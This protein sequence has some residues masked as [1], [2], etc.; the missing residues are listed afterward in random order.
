VSCDADVP[1]ELIGDDERLG[2]ILDI[3][4]GNA[5]STT[6][7]G[8]VIVG[9]RISRDTGPAAGAPADPSADA[10]AT[11][12]G[13]ADDGVYA[14]ITL[15]VS[16][17]G[18]GLKDSE[19]AE[20]HAGAASAQSMGALA[21]DA[22]R[23]LEAKAT[24]HGSDARARVLET[25][26]AH[27]LAICSQLVKLFGS[28]VHVWTASTEGTILSF[29]VR[30]KVNTSPPPPSRAALVLAA[31]ALASGPLKRVVI[32]DPCDDLRAVLA[33]GLAAAIP[34]I[35]I[36]PVTT[37]A[38]ARTAALAKADSGLGTVVFLNYPNTEAYSQFVSEA[39]PAVA[40]PLDAAAAK[41]ASASAE[42]VALVAMLPLN[43]TG[44]TA[45][46]AASFD[47]RTPYRLSK[48]VAVHQLLDLLARVCED[49]M[50]PTLPSPNTMRRKTTRGIAQ[51][52]SS[53]RLGGSGLVSKCGFI[54][55]YIYVLEK[56][57]FFFFFFFFFCFQCC[58]YSFIH[59]GIGITCNVYI[60]IFR[61][62]IKRGRN[63]AI[64]IGWRTSQQS[65][66]WRNGSRAAAGADRR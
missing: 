20:L 62:R 26:A 6:S 58:A 52:S 59:H 54:R 15:S 14:S 39:D 43:G 21:E 13:P 4:V 32:C 30:L 44:G 38:Q 16:D 37:P 60:F 9:A 56:S 7:S 12:A 64:H 53:S 25:S 45:G 63:H 27:K 22:Y 65:W 8:E 42:R 66:R 35:S 34:S 57:F 3:L 40:P 46:G 51:T 47:V 24:P 50:I 17:T 36:V 5:V 10:A 49:R 55:I 19:A 2:D 41:A 33:S 48:P 1:Q 11:A 29:T 23:R 31:S 28:E 18:L 61:W